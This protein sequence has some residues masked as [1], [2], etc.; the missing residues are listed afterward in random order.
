MG[1]DKW[2]QVVDPAWY[3]GSEE[4]RDAAVARLPRVLLAPRAGWPVPPGV[5]VLDVHPDHLEVS[6]TAAVAGRPDWLL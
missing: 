4:A 2:A 1:A 6:S 3:G 5:E